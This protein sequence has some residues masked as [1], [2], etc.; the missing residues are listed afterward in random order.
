[1]AMAS[2]AATIKRLRGIVD[3]IN[4]SIRV[5]GSGTTEA[6][7]LVASYARAREKFLAIA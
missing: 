7:T 1:M 6:W 3:D 2:V 5:R 4:T